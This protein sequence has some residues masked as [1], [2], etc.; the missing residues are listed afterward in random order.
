MATRNF[1][2]IK[3]S[4]PPL[5]LSSIGKGGW[6]AGFYQTARNIIKLTCNILMSTCEINILTCDLNYVACHHYYFAC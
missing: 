4:P 6:E 2:L 1:S 5:L 3:T